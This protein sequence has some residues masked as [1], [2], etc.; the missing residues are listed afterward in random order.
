MIVE[1]L[2][3][4]WGDDKAFLW[5]II[6]NLGIMGQPLNPSGTTDSVLLTMC[7]ASPRKNCP[8]LAVGC[9]VGSNK[10]CQIFSTV[11]ASPSVGCL[12][13]FVGLGRD[14]FS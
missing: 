5:F 3:L 7:I 14:V 1:S 13:R 2:H 9:P 6:I 10:G 8:S 12:G 11:V 4:L